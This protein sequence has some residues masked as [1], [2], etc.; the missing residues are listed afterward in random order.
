M[1]A[2]RVRN[3]VNNHRFSNFSCEIIIQII[4]YKYVFYYNANLTHTFLYVSYKSRFTLLTMKCVKFCFAFLA[5]NFCC[6]FST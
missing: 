5:I 3:T 6:F 1:A 2:D 4:I